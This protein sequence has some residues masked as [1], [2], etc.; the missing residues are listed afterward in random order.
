MLAQAQGRTQKRSA[1]VG[2]KRENVMKIFGGLPY[3]SGVR[4]CTVFKVL[5]YK[6]EGRWSIPEGVIGIFH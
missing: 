5:C 1:A 3:C 6:S 2:G 4:G